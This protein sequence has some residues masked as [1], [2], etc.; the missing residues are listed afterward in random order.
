MIN[1]PYFLAFLLLTLVGSA[2]AQ[3]TLSVSNVVPRKDTE[4]NI[5]DAHDGS[6][7]AFEGKFYW[8]G[9]SYASTNGFTSANTM[10]CYSSDDLTTW[11]KEKNFI[12]NPPV[13]VSYRPKVIYNKATRKYVLWYNWYAKLWVGQYAVGI[14][15]TPNGPFRLIDTDVK[16]SHP[17]AG[18]FNLMVDDDGT[19]YMSY[20]TIDEHV[21][22]VE[23]LNR[24]FTGSTLESSEA[25]VK[26]S[27]AS[28]M[29]KRGKYY[30]LLTDLL[31]CFCGEGSGVKVFK[32]EYPTKGYVYMG[33]INRY[34]GQI[35]HAANDGNKNSRAGLSISDTQS[36]QIIL[37]K[38]Q[39]VN[40]LNIVVAES[41][42]SSHCVIKAIDSEGIMQIV[43]NEKEPEFVITY[44]DKNGNWNPI[45]AIPIKKT[46]YRSTT[47]Y[48][49]SFPAVET[50]ELTIKAKAI[51]YN[52][53]IPVSEIEVLVNQTNVGL[54]AR[55]AIVL[56][57]KSEVIPFEAAHLPVIIPA[58]QTFVAQI[59]TAKGTV[60][61]WMGDLWGS[62]PDG[63]KGHDFQYWSSPLQFDEAGMIQPLRWE[64]SWTLTR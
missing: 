61:I 58:Q 47:S 14:A 59:P 4:G 44:K 41:R 29:F 7:I 34:A 30:Y 52:Q 53:T 48:R 32:S 13:G 15:D 38:K 60:Y 36:A 24:D 50:S 20:N 18:D 11:K 21:I 55:E 54:A 33:N 28:A 31:C 27:E 43:A 16:M 23:K 26:E 2:T 1:Y 37:S 42:Y 40:Q 39:P 51:P 62:R 64:D 45:N 6:L 17:K 57:V 46:E 25:I 63:V 35:A 10:V 5:V 56:E 3:S 22:Y 12:L 8:Y 9:T 49:Y 19:A